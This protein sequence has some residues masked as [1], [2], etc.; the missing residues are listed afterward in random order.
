MT[1]L[2]RG[3]AR[4][5][6]E[7]RKLL[8]EFSAPWCKQCRALN[9]RLEASDVSKAL[10]EFEFLVLNVGGGHELDD[11]RRSLDARAI[12]SW[13][14]LETRACDRPPAEWVRVARTYPTK[15]PRPLAEWL[16]GA[17]D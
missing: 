13:T 8:V 2:R 9:E 3:C 14:V 6:D 7:Q 1:E 5:G 15:E 12:P 11:L 4:A 17:A 16:R 10:G